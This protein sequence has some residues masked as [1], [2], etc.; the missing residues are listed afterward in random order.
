MF[1]MGGFVSRRTR[2]RLLLGFAA[3]P[4]LIAAS[5]AGT[6][7]GGIPQVAGYAGPAQQVSE[8]TSAS[9]VTSGQFSTRNWDGYLTYVSSEAK[10]FN[11][12]KATWVQPVITCPVANAW[13]VFWVGLDGWW[14][15]T[16]EQGGSSARCVGGIPQYDLWWEMYPTN[17]IQLMTGI[18]VGAGDTIRASVV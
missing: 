9:G 3:A 6:Q 14:N 17:S 10:D 5:F 1:E 2:W 18:A 12:V 16:V 11:S 8:T 13:T 15:D 7:A 4:V